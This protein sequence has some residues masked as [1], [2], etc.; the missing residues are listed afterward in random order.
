MEIRGFVRYILL[1]LCCSALGI[2]LLSVLMAL[3]YQLCPVCLGGV[4]S[5]LPYDPNTAKDMLVISLAS[6]SVACVI[7]WVMQRGK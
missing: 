4:V 6:L 3:L 7:Y 5:D 2:A 1:V